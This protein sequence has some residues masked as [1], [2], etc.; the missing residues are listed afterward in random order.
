ML[1]LG[2]RT[3]TIVRSE[4]A[5]RDSIGF[6]KYALRY[7][8]E[9]FVKVLRE[10][11]QPPAYPLAILAVSWPIRAIVGDATPQA[12]ALSAQIASAF[13][14][15]LLVFPMASFGAELMNRRLGIVA[16]ALFQCLPAWIRFT[17]D[18]IS[19]STFLFFTAM[20]LW[21]AARAFRARSNWSMASCGI[22]AGLAFL[23]RPEGA[24]IVV[25]VAAVLGGLVAL[26]HWQRRQAALS[27]VALVAGFLICFGPLVAAT[28]R[29]TNKPTG[30]FL[31][32]DP[33]AEQSYFGVARPG[34]TLLA[35]WYLDAGQPN[36][37]KFFWSVQA[38]VV[39]IAASSRLIGL[40]LSIVGLVFWR[41]RIL[42]APAGAVMMALAG[43]HAALLLRMA[44]QIGYLSERHTA[45]I[46]L[47]GC[48][49]AALG[50][51]EII[52]R[53]LRI[54][55][56]QSLTA[57]AIWVT[58][59]LVLA[60]TAEI[61]SLAKSMHSNRAGHRAAGEWLAHNAPAEAGIRDPFCWAQYYAGRDFRETATADPDE[62]F[63]IVETS[64]SQHSRLPLLPE[65]KAKAT[66]GE[67][68]FHWPERLPA[69]KAQVAV[70]RWLRPKSPNAS[71]PFPPS[72]GDASDRIAVVSP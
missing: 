29:V 11:Q 52:L 9:P 51:T 69:E 37:S 67:M 61:P 4:V 55:F 27:F 56:R 28:G 68:V 2:L 66:A 63:V 47:T 50:L 31:L 10:A 49:P 43:L 44:S 22:M 6:I 23:T 71:R 60:F 26:G 16:A 46:V 3:W 1:A 7:E 5:A 39:E 34:P 12:M 30:R 15:V 58:T 33:T 42:N 24:E 65:V 32:G 38:L 57:Q 36:R 18:G 72:G 19:E 62:Q 64:D 45:L 70:Y 20:A 54:R 41:K 48:Y 21:L 53:M 8:N 40:L 14:G 35:V 59:I 17:S 25:A 13:F